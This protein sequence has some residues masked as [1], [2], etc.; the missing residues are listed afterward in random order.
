MCVLGCFLS[1]EQCCSVLCVVQASG[2]R[3]VEMIPPA[4]VVTL[5]TTMVTLQIVTFSILNK[6]LQIESK[7]RK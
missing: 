6:W 3:T 5:Q 7:K 2:H 4:T 1:E